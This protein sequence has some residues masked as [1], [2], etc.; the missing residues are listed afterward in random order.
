MGVGVSG[1]STLPVFN[2]V[3]EDLEEEKNDLLPRSYSRES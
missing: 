3:L 1:G 2:L